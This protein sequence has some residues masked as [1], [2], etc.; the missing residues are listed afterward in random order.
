MT[1]VQVLNAAPVRHTCSRCTW[2]GIVGSAQHALM[3]IQASS[4]FL[5]PHAYLHMLCCCSC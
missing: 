5:S 4:D 1:G 2:R 3:L